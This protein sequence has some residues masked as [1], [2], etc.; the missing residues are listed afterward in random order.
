VLGVSAGAHPAAQLALRHP[1]KVDAL[2]LVV[3]ALYVPPE[4]GAPPATG[5]PAIITDYVLR[6]DF[7]V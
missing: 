2:A 4:P 3:P 5:P 1:E 6:S 7:L